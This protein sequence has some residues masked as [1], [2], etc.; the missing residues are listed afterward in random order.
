M[1]NIFRIVLIV[2]LITATNTSYSQEEKIT[3]AEKI[4]GWYRFE[5]GR[6]GISFFAGLDGFEARDEDRNIY[7]YNYMPSIRLGYNYIPLNSFVINAEI[8][9]AYS[10]NHPSYD[11][12]NIMYF[13]GLSK[14]FSGKNKFFMGTG[15]DFVTENF[16]YRIHPEVPDHR[17][18][19]DTEFHKL[20]SH[21]MYFLKPNV[22]FGYCFGNNITLQTGVGYNVY[23][24]DKKLAPFSGDIKFTYFFPLKNKEK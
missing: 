9:Y 19:G 24:G 20:N 5:K 6:H 23:L 21:Y 22:Y 10:F 2:L 16:R 12:Q 15:V 4:P 11:R 8:I 13:V 3:L 7:A 18:F 1:K 17:Y 14:T